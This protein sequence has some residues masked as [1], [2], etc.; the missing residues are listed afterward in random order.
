MGN[1]AGTSEE[2][3]ELMQMAVAKG[4]QAHIERFELRQI[5]EVLQRLEQGEIDGRAVVRIPQ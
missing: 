3:N 5:N 4:V 2:M 1:S